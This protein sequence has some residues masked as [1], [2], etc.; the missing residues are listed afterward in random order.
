MQCEADVEG[1]E[2]M[3][4]YTEVIKHFKRMCKSVTPMKCTRGEC[5]MGC[6]NIGQCR[7]VAFERP[8]QFEEQVMAWAAENPEPVYPTWWKFLC[9]IGVIPGELGDKTL[10]EATV[11]NL[12]NTHIQSDFAEKLGIDPKAGGET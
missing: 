10:G 5:L 2:M 1:S 3:A 11:Y 9:M 4:E 8:E 12:M 6:E 7:K